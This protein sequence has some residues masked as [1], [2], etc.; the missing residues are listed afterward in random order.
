MRAR[1]SD[2]LAPLILLRTILFV[3][4]CDK[5]DSSLSMNEGNSLTRVNSISDYRLDLVVIEL[6]KAIL[7]LPKRLNSPRRQTGG[8]PVS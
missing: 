8:V 5:N 2:D 1:P 7:C 3:L 6:S 4:P